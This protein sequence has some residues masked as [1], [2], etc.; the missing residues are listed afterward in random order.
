MN[1]KKNTQRLRCLSL[2]VL[3]TPLSTPSFISTLPPPE[4]APPSPA[5]SQKGLW[6][7]CLLISH[8]ISPPHWCVTLVKKARSPHSRVYCRFE[9]IYHSGGLL[10]L[11]INLITCGRSWPGG[12]LW[13][14]LF[15]SCRHQFSSLLACKP[16]LGGAA[17]PLPLH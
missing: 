17:H 11:P 2:K 1:N 13:P 5:A 10:R 12:P 7:S 14:A 6:L 15:V 4:T 3:R 8:L 16:L 9:I